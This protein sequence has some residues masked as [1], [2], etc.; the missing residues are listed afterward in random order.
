MRLADAAN[1]FNKLVCYD[2]YSGDPVFRAQLG[3]YDDTK[4]DS[5]VAERRVLSV[6]PGT[7]FPARGV[8]QAAGRQWILGHRNT[9]AFGPNEIR[10]GVVLHEATT[11]ATVRTLGQLARNEAGFNAWCGY[12]W[13]KDKA[14]TEQSSKLDPQLHVHFAA[15]EPVAQGLVVQLGTRYTLARSTTLGG[16][17]TLVTTVEEMP[18]PVVETATV[19][20]S[21][22]DKVAGMFVGGTLTTARVLR[23]RWQSLFEYG[24]VSGPTFGPE[25]MQLVMATAAATPR[26][27]SIVTLSDGAWMIASARAQDDVWL[28]RATRHART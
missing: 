7:K 13:V 2:A 28:C 11:L 5:E 8:I 18:D 9:D 15:S 3:L 20:T 4:R 23:V 17:G 1:R 26:V 21:D 10:Q 16:G 14:F 6:A 24:N 22:W 12:A 27:G 19:S 25:D